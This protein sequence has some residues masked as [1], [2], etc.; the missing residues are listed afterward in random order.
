MAYGSVKV[1]TIIFDNNGSDQNV[2]VSGLYRATTSGITVTGTISGVALVGTTV[3]GTTVTGNIVQGTTVQG[4]SGTF[5]SLTGT[6]TSGTT[7]NFVSGVFTTQVSGTTVTGT[8][9]QFTTGTF[10]SLTGTTITGT[11]INGVTVASTTGTFGSL[12]GTTTTG[13][14]AN[15]VTG[16]FSTSVSGVTVLGTT[17]TFTSLT[18]TTISGQTY[19][20]SGGVTFVTESGNIR[21]Y[22]LYSFPAATSTYGF[23]LV[24]NGDGTTAW[25][26]RTKSVSATATTGTL[27]PD[28]NTTDIFIASGLTGAVTFAAPTGSPANG[29]KLL[30]RIKDN[31]TARALTWT[32]SAGGYRVIGIV[33]PTTTVSNK[34]IYVGCIYNSADSFW[35]SVANVAQG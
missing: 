24:T 33:L 12:T 28:S 17:G 35:D 29:Q 3:S 19:I 25:E 2:T 20:A 21:P 7:A 8:T 26:N 30:I 31:G 5:T 16:N 27:T 1:D 10:V 34:T 22:G 6:T 15:F 32:T 23:R 14:T 4:V 11:T 18:G 13:T 9:A